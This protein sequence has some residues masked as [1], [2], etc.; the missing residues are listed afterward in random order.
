MSQEITI[1]EVL[2]KV[3][4]WDLEK[5]KRRL[6]TNETWPERLCTEVDPI[7]RRLMTLK[8]F[9]PTEVLIPPITIDTF[10]HAHMLDSMVYAQDCQN[11]FGR[12]IHHIPFDPAELTPE[13]RS[14]VREN[15][16]KTLKLY[17][18]SFG[19]LNPYSKSVWENPY[20]LKIDFAYM[21]RIGVGQKSNKN[22][23]GTSSSQSTTRGLNN[24]GPPACR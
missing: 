16:D 8:G 24:F 9:F 6:V 14:E 13:L 19:E 18:A 17:V 1:N 2:V 20:P 7:Y 21:D 22:P 15:R 23:S 3:E 4:A 10:W 11:A 5:T 12:F